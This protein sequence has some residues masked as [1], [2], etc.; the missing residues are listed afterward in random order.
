VSLPSHA[1]NE[2]LEATGHSAGFFLS[3]WVGGC[4]PRL[5][6]SVI[7]TRG[8]EFYCWT[9]Q[10]SCDSAMVWCHLFPNRGC[11]AGNGGVPST[12]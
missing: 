3:S 4:G 8:R 9:Q 7:A 5:S 11:V 6:L 12:R 1:P 10:G 2:A